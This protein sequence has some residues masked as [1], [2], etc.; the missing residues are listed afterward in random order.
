M[1]LD[2]PVS[3]STMGLVRETNLLTTCY[4]EGFKVSKSQ[5]HHNFLFSGPMSAKA[6]TMLPGIV[7]VRG[8]ALAENIIQGLCYTGTVPCTQEE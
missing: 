7:I 3:K 2:Y 8:R 1:T 6:V 4:K 5:K